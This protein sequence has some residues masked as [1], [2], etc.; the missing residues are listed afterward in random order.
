MVEA[1]VET[2]GLTK[3]YG[4]IV[5]VDDLDFSVPRGTVMGLLGPNGAGKTTIIGTLLGLIRPTA[6]SISLFGS[7]V[8]GAGDVQVRG[9]GAIMETPA[10]YPFLSG[11]DNLRYFQGISGRDDPEETRRLLDLVGLSDR[12]EAKFSTYSLGM[13]HR[14]GIAYALQGDP[15]LLLLDEP[16]NGLDPAGMAEVRRLIRALGDGDRTILLA[17]HLLNEVEQVCDR[18]AILSRGRIIAEGAVGDLLGRQ[19][20]LRLRTTDDLAAA[21]LVAALDWV[22]SVVPQPGGLVVA[23]EPDRSWELTAALAEH[24][25]FVSEL[26]TLETS[27][28]EYFLEVTEE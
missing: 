23:A 11:R 3:R 14:L 27:L 26:T 25:V 13:K 4:D 7:A 16:T 21:E 20:R 2:R 24:S 28:E 17:S 18:V 19:N 6:G 22:G 8:D 15:D 10:F 5:A 9:I 12:A 1:V